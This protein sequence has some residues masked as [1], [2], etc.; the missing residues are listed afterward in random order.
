MNQSVLQQLSINRPWWNLWVSWPLQREH[1]TQTA[2]TIPTVE[3]SHSKFN[4]A[5]P[6]PP[7]SGNQWPALLTGDTAVCWV[8]GDRWETGIALSLSLCGCVC[9]CMC[10]GGM[11]G[12]GTSELVRLIVS[13]T[14]MLSHTSDGLWEKECVSTCRRGVSEGDWLTAAPRV[15]SW[16]DSLHCPPHSLTALLLRRV[17]FP[18]NNALHLFN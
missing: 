9:G 18:S 1:C 6:I 8:E 16:K 17:P 14:D 3:F 5:G 12:G 10:V 7:Y 13:H 15:G 11:V 4:T 2:A